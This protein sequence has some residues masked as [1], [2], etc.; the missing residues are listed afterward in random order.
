MFPKVRQSVAAGTLS[1]NLQAFG[2]TQNSHAYDIL[3]VGRYILVIAS[4]RQLPS[5]H[6]H[7]LCMD[8]P[9]SNMPC[10]YKDPFCAC[11]ESN[12][13]AASSHP[14]LPPFL[15]LSL[16]S[17]SRSLSLSRLSLSLS[18]SLSSLSLSLSL[19]PPFSVTLS[20]SLSLSLSLFLFSH[21]IYLCTVPL[22][23]SLHPPPAP[24]PGN[25]SLYK[26]S[27]EPCC[28]QT[29]CKTCTGCNRNAFK[30]NRHAEQGCKAR[31]QCFSTP[32]Y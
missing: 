6:A 7:A 17:L 4:S 26:S 22:T 16:L 24:C 14:F 9:A 12:M 30:Q 29:N 31:W 13:L 8:L 25:L 32:T 20:L 1:P 5:T 19:S 18:L 10:R 15:S 23:P 3:E 27:H 28:T 11:L 21:S 2:T